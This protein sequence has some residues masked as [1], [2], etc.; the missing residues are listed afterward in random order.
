MAQPITVTDGVCFA[1]PDVCQTPS[2]GGPVPIPYP[3]IAQ[4]SSATD[5][6]SSVNAGGKPVVIETSSIAT[7]SGDEAGTGG[8]GPIG[9][10]TFTTF[11]KTV[12]ANGK[13]IVRLGDTTSQNAG[14]AVGAVLGGLPTVLV[15]G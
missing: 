1:F 10:C 15:G 14:N 7:S 3:N 9:K 12:K 13:G 2:P 4:L 5:T 11:S 8:P 6:A